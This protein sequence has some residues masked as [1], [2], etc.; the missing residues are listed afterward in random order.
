MDL[1]DIHVSLIL[2]RDIWEN[3]IS[4]YLDWF[5]DLPKLKTI[6]PEL[7]FRRK[8]R[9]REEKELNGKQV[10]SIRYYLDDYLLEEIFFNETSTR[11][12][13]HIFYSNSDPRGTYVKS[14][15]FLND[16]GL[17]TRR[18]IGYSYD[19]IEEK[20]YASGGNVTFEG[21]SNTEEKIGYV[22][23]RDQ[24]L[25]QFYSKNKDEIRRYIFSQA[26]HNMFEV[27]YKRNNRTILHIYQNFFHRSTHII[28]GDKKFW[29]WGCGRKGNETQRVA[30]GVYY[31]LNRYFKQLAVYICEGDNLSISPSTSKMYVYDISEYDGKVPIYSDFSKIEFKEDQ[32]LCISECKDAEKDGYDLDLKPDVGYGVYRDDIR[33]GFWKF[34]ENGVCIE[35][36]EFQNNESIRCYVEDEEIA[37]ILNREL[38][39]NEKEKEYYDMAVK[40]SLGE[41][42]LTIPR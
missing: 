3:I 29:K 28:E 25:E 23:D 41:S 31:T 11:G 15:T 2:P 12:Y 20:N 39:G 26:N 30:R 13:D 1:Q 37:E 22:W 40:A 8:P 36:E 4:R 18:I 24:N 17:I 9:L 27:S 16:K 21:Y 10:D 7:N 5:H 14:A 6:F 34:F 33:E 42:I 19:Y 38:V 35:I 32:L